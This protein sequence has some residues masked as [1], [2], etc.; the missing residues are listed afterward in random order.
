[1]PE[2]TVKPKQRLLSLDVF[3]GATIAAMI[4]V[5]NPGDWSHI[6]PP[7]EHSK[8]NGCT[9]TDLIF[10]F[11]LFMVGVSIIFAMQSKKAEGGGHGKLIFRAFRRMV[12]LI[13]ISLLIQLFYHPDLAT[14][15]Y[16]GVLQR[17]AIVYFIC[18]LL[19]LKVTFRNR[20]LLLAFVLVAYYVLMTFVPVPNLGHANLNPETNMG[21]WLD[22]MVF[23]PAHLWRESN[24]WDPEGLLGTLPAIGTGLLGMIAGRWLKHPNYK[25]SVKVSWMFVYGVAAV[26]AGLLWGQFFPIN[27]SLWTSSF[28]LYTGGLATLLLA[29]CYWLIDINGNNRFAWIFAV[30]GTNA[31]TA[32]ILSGILPGLIGF[33]HINSGG[34]SLNANAYISQHFF[35]PYLSPNNAS[36]ASAL[37]LVILI[38]LILLPLYRKNI[39]IKV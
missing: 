26:A 1:M 13:V 33:I 15:R 20:N 21:A 17:I 12:L 27:K 14:L 39:V 35:N 18:T 29:G 36:L 22:R 3:R 28:V 25:G 31:I 9:P 23:T 7:L 8:W 30:F 4:L 2:L 6:Y 32:Y 19:Y 24:T 37:L 5:N 34:R 38:W 16:P 10:P 11:F